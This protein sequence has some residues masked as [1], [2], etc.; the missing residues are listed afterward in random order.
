MRFFLGDRDNQV[1]LAAA[2]IGLPG[3]GQGQLDVRLLP[4]GGGDHQ[5]DE[6]DDQDVDQGDDDNR[7]RRASF[8]EDEMHGSAFF[9]DAIEAAEELVAQRFHLDSEGLDL[10]A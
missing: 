5:E 4:E 10:F 2:G 1:G 9:A 8:A 7:R 3:F 6:Q